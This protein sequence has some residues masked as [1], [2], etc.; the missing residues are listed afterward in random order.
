MDLHTLGSLR[1]EIRSD[2]TEKPLRRTG[3]GDIHHE[4]QFTNHPPVILEQQLDDE[5]RSG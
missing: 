5:Q 4:R 3:E 1:E 2:V